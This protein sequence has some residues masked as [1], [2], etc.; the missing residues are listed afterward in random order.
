[1]AKVYV[2]DIGTL[3]KLSTG[4][5]LTD[6]TDQSIFY[7]KPGGTEIEK[8]ALVESP[9]SSGI[10]YFTL[11]DGDFDEAGEYKFQAWVEFPSGEWYGE[12]ATLTVY[13]R[14]A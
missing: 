2:G 5:N 10:I 6:A 11:A 9:A 7:K 14:Y 3:I 12:T 4:V 1:M 13:S 8:A